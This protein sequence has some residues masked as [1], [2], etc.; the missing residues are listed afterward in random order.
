MKRKTTELAD[1][2]AQLCLL[3]E[4]N[5]KLKKQTNLDKISE[6]IQ[7]N[8]RIKNEL[9]KIKHHGAE[10]ETEFEEGFEK[11]SV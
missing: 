3:K 6:L 11:N 5:T 1:V 7:E 8:R 9:T 4:E 10:T 2:H